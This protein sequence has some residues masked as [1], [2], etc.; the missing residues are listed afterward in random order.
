MFEPVSNKVDF[1]ALEQEVLRRWEAEGTFERS[2]EQRCG[3][4]HTEL[5]A[6]RVFGRTF[7]TLHLSLRMA[8]RSSTWVSRKRER[9]A[10]AHRLRARARR[11]G[12]APS[13]W[14]VLIEA[15]WHLWRPIDRSLYHLAILVGDCPHQGDWVA[16]TI[17][18]ADFVNHEFPKLVV[19]RHTNSG[20]HIVGGNDCSR[21]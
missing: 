21:Y 5:G 9:R 8:C 2:L 19:V 4:I 10:A 6:F 18:G 14:S 3:A 16:D 1:P 12:L 15:Y 20:D 13:S 11:R 7:G 17:D